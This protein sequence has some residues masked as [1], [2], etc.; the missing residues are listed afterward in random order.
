MIFTPIKDPVTSPP[1]I[2]PQKIFDVPVQQ[3]H[4]AWSN[5]P[6]SLFS[7]DISK[8]SIHSSQREEKRE[9]RSPTQT[10]R[11]QFAKL[12]RDGG[13]MTA[14]C[15]I[16]DEWGL[17]LCHKSF[18][19]RDWTRTCSKVHPDE[20]TVV[21]SVA[22]FT[23]VVT[24]GIAVSGLPPSGV[25]LLTLCDQLFTIDA[26]YAASIVKIS[27]VTNNNNNKKR[28]CAHTNPGTGSYR[29]HGTQ[30]PGLQGDSE[31]EGITATKA[32]FTLAST[33]PHK[34]T[35][36]KIQAVPKTEKVSDTRY[37][38]VMQCNR[39][40][41]QPPTIP[42]S[43]PYKINTKEV[44][45]SLS[46]T[47]KDKE[48][49]SYIWPVDCG[50]FTHDFCKWFYTLLNSQ[51]ESSGLQK[52]DW[53][54]QHFLE[55]AVLQLTYMSV[56]TKYNGGRS[57]SARL[58]A[59]VHEDKLSFQPN[60]TSKGIKCKKSPEGIVVM[61]VSGTIFRDNDFFGTFDQVFEVVWNSTSNNWKI[62]FI[63]LNIQK[64]ENNEIMK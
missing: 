18:S 5:V 43:S 15:Q 57:A 23:S 8:L 11:P 33:V 9:Q 21:N 25:L 50:K 29:V 58:L 46:S 54:P 39:K 13:V 20:H 7:T 24:S 52:K 28:S 40:V 10:C 34:T 3:R 1:V 59:L 47:T 6:L 45:T 49:T 35:H 12:K 22:E 31:D 26:A 48:H 42:P 14:A 44:V 2:K 56:K 62:Q 63:V 19:S 16:H 64:I 17:S 55:N 37:T 32:T 41:F 51:H 27:N 30:A 4:K 61:M 60:L 53:G 38:N 36:S